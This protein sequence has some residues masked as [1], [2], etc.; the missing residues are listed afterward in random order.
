MWLPPD[1]DGGSPIIGYVLE[2]QENK[3]EEWKSTEVKVQPVK[4]HV[5]AETPEEI[6]LKIM[7]EE[8]AVQTITYTVTGL[9][10]GTI[11]LFRVKAK[12]KKGV[13]EALFMKEK[14]FTKQFTGI[15]WFLLLMSRSTTKPPKSP[16]HPAKTQISLGICPGWSE[17]SLVL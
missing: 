15:I 8:K 14:I 7:L 17:S 12:N 5:P 16:V 6:P 2:W 11:Y 10:D 9:T 3:S 4:V 1:F 13:G